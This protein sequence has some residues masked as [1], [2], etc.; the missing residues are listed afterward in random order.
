MVIVLLR[1]PI[2]YFP[3]SF[4]ELK[5]QIQHVWKV[6]LVLKIIVNSVTALLNLHGGRLVKVQ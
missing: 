5:Q 3:L 4:D 6:I 2:L 1:F